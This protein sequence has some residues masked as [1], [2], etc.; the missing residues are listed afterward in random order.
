MKKSDTVY[1][2]IYAVRFYE[3]VRLFMR[4]YGFIIQKVKLFMRH[5][6]GVRNGNGFITLHSNQKQSFPLSLIFWLITIILI[7]RIISK[8]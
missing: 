8:N 1:F 5:K 3:K 2:L 6:K 7:T 4:I